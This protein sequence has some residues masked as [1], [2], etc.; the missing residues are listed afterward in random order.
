[1]VSQKNA[2][3]ILACKSHLHSSFMDGFIVA[4]KNKSLYFFNYA[5]PSIS[6]G[7]FSDVF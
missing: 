1:M 6:Y 5:N 7:G 3:G 4:I 2:L